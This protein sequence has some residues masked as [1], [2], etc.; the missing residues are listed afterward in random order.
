M[1]KKELSQYKELVIQVRA[2]ESELHLMKTSDY[3]IGSSTI[4]N[5]SSGFAKPESV[6]GFDHKKYDG[7]R[8]NLEKKKEKLNEIEIWI[9]DIPD[10]QTRL[11]FKLR[12]IQCLKWSEIAA[13]IGFPGND[14]YPRIAIRDAYFKKITFYKSFSFFSVFSV[15]I[16]DGFKGSREPENPI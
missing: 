2:L 6:V 12:Y 8:K 3:G 13:K 11:V 5:Y 15:Y 10:D 14:D 16:K 1:T 7:K 9:E 4:F